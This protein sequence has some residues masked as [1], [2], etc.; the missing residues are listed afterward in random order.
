[1]GSLKTPMCYFQ[2]IEKRKKV[3]IPLKDITKHNSICVK[4]IK[5]ILVNSCQKDVLQFVFI[6]AHN[7][8]VNPECVAVLIGLYVT[9]RIL[10]RFQ[11]K[12]EKG[13]GTLLTMLYTEQFK[14]WDTCSLALTLPV[15]N[16]SI[17]SQCCVRMWA[18]IPYA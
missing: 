11:L 17:T 14:S 9:L 5:K 15:L 2:Q 8:N 1:M 16:S 13:S 18:A 12:I 7:D 6:L 4:P 10:K 3:E